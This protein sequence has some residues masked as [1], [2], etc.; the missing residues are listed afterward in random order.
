M[1]QKYDKKYEVQTM[2]L[3]R[4]IGNSDGGRCHDNAKC[5]SMWAKMKEEVFKFWR[6]RNG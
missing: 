2:L 1:S 5:E 3:A 4:K 6:L